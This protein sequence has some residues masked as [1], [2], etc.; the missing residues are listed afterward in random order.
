M[1][2]INSSKE[3]FIQKKKMNNEVVDITNFDQ[4]IA[5][6]LWLIDKLKNKNRTTNDDMHMEEEFGKVVELPKRKLNRPIISESVKNQV[7]LHYQK[8]KLHEMK[9]QI[10]DDEQK[11]KEREELIEEETHGMS[12]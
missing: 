8:Q 9:Q 1:R 10:L 11:R 2:L 12:M 4:R 6:V 3:N 5:R 7:I